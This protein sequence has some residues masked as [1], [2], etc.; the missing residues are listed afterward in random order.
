MSQKNKTAMYLHLTDKKKKSLKTIAEKFNT[1]QT[2]LIEE[3]VDMIIIKYSKKY[4]ELDT[5]MDKFLK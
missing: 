4:I 1:T 2:S 3:A 5:I